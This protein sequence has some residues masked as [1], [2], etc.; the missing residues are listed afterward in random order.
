MQ[1]RYN[2]LA[3]HA[4]FSRGSNLLAR[5]GGLFFACVKRFTKSCPKFFIGGGGLATLLVG[6]GCGAQTI[7]TQLL[8][9]L[10]VLFGTVLLLVGHVDVT[11]GGSPRGGV[12]PHTTARQ[13]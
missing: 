6:G 12:K 4:G 9:M 11:A 3:S 7:F 10:E 5:F 1:A 2:S 13:K 8:Q